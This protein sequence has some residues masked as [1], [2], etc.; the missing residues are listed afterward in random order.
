LL[1]E[2][3]VITMIAAVAAAAAMS[4]LRRFMRISILCTVARCR[5]DGSPVINRT[6][7]RLS[8]LAAMLSDS[9]PPRQCFRSTPKAVAH[10]ARHGAQRLKMRAG[11]RTVNVHRDPEIGE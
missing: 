9:E 2:Q 4:G 11:G 5:A 7:N 3:A 1:L 8:G 10:R 6:T